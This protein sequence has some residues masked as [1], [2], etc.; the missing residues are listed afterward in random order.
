MGAQ[1]SAL[2]RRDAD[3]VCTI[4]LNRPQKRNAL[5]MQL[6][7][8]VIDALDEVDARPDIH[9]VVIE[10]NGPV[11]CS[12]HDLK[13]VRSTPS[14]DFYA[15]LFARCSKMMMRIQSI[16]QPVIAKIQGPASAAGCQLVATCDL[17]LASETATFTTPGVNIGLF[18]STPMVALSRTVHRK[19]AMNMLLTGQP[20]D[21]ER[22]FDIGLVSTVTK[23]SDLDATCAALASQI[24]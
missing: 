19:H 4:T 11:F 14:A 16:R 2:L 3:H 24:A 12:G 18:C 6:M 10:A 9:V 17:A 23:Q 13:E 5:S 20:I 15:E 21:A 8:D 1:T 7:Q 22:A